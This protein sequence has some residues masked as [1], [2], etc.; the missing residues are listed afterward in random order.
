MHLAHLSLYLFIFP[1]WR[2]PCS[3]L[4]TCSLSPLLSS[5]VNLVQYKI[6]CFTKRN[7]DL[8]VI[9]AQGLLS[10]CLGAQGPTQFWGSSLSL[11]HVT[12]MLDLSSCGQN[13]IINHYSSGFIFE[14]HQSHKD[15]S[16]EDSIEVLGDQTLR[17]MVSVTWGSILLGPQLPPGKSCP[18]PYNRVE[19]A[20]A[21]SSSYSEPSIPRWPF[22]MLVC[23]TDSPS[24]RSWCGQVSL[25]IQQSPKCLWATYS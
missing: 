18:S 15:F 24:G 7:I 6:F 1:L 23:V 21:T 5:E 3:L 11:L 22:H 20:E 8:W 14:N 13:D 9:L 17:D 2:S 10:S 12:S 16:V 4:N 25:I 19:W